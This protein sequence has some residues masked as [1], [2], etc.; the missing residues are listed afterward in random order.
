MEETFTCEKRAEAAASNSNMKTGIT[1]VPTEVD[2]ISVFDIKKYIDGEEEP[3]P[4]MDTE[5]KG[6]P[7]L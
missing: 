3:D 1:G 7:K 6:T 4:N 2:E 5:D